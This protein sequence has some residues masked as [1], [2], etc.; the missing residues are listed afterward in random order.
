MVRV[1]EGQWPQAD[2]RGQGP[3]VCPPLTVGRCGGQGSGVGG[4]SGSCTR[5]GQ[6]MGTVAPGHITKGAQ[7]ARG[8]GAESPRHSYKRNAN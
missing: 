2:E 4:P 8:T 3:W 5:G 6:G 7:P 1:Q